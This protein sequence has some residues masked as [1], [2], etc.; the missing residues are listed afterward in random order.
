[1]PKFKMPSQKRDGKVS[2]PNVPAA[3]S[4]EHPIFCLKYLRNGYQVDD[5]DEE[6]KGQVLRRLG[7]A[8]QQTW[9][10][11]LS[12]HHTSGGFERIPTDGFR[13]GLPSEFQSEDKAYVLRLTKR[14]RIV[15]FRKDQ[16]FF[17]VWLDQ[18]HNLYK[19]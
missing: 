16:I 18:L 1:M 13:G 11:L 6:T 14:G 9:S 19:G 5:C 3:L 15:G 4:D 10:G 8:A 17:I 7:I 2:A 12:R